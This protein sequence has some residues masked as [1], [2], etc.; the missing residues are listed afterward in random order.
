[1]VPSLRSFGRISV[2]P[3]TSLEDSDSDDD[4]S[5]LAGDSLFRAAESDSNSALDSDEDMS[6]SEEEL[7]PPAKARHRSIDMDEVS[8]DIDLDFVGSY[9][10]IYTTG[11]YIVPENFPIVPD[12]IR[13]GSQPYGPQYHLGRCT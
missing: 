8:S 6:E 1:M 10:D 13:V 2:V 12:L 5:A 4:I 7:S 9:N 3:E 11:N